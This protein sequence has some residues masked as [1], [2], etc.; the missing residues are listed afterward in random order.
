MIDESCCD[1]PDGA[2]AHTP[3]NTPNFKKIAELVGNTLKFRNANVLDAEFILM[4]R[5]DAKKGKHLSSTSPEIV[6]QIN[7]LEQYKHDN[8]QIYFI[9]EDFDG[10]SVGTVRLYDKKGDSFCWG[11]WVLIDKS[12]IHYSIESAL[13]VYSI[14]MYLG[15]VASHFDVRKAN[16]S[17]CNFH[18]KFGAIKVAETSI[19]YHYEIGL[20]AIL[21]SLNKFKK[22]LPHGIS[23]KNH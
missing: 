21:N 15:F 8:S 18:E 20:H 4:L 12:P 19:S 23:I 13:I 1:D 9:I 7:W 22:F 2:L 3:A 10:N 17:V 14:G 11:S 5:L 6:D 16:S